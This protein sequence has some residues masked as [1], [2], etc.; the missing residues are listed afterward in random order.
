M[1][2]G[3]TMTEGLGFDDPHRM[4]PH[5]DALRRAS[6]LLWPWDMPEVQEW[7][8]ALLKNT[9]ESWDDDASSTAIIEDYLHHLEAEVERLGGCRRRWCAWDDDEP[10]DHGYLTEPIARPAANGREGLQ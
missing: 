5:A 6:N 7:E 10:C 8:N 4:M 3:I 9:P 2:R 1:A